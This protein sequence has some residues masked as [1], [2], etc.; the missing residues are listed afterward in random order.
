MRKPQAS[1]LTQLVKNLPAMQ[2][3]RVRFLGWEDPLEKEMAARS[4]ILARTIPW[5][6]EPGGLHSPWG[7]KNRTRQGLNHHYHHQGPPWG[8]SRRHPNQEESAWRAESRGGVP[9][10]D[11]WG[12]RPTE[13]PLPAPEASTMLLLDLGECPALGQSCALTKCALKRLPSFLLRLPQRPRL[14]F[15]TRVHQPLLSLHIHLLCFA[16]D[17]AK[18]RPEE[19]EPL[20]NPGRC[21]CLMP[22]FL[23][24]LCKLMRPA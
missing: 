10:T 2:E 12:Q 17:A 16:G 18:R 15:P 11:G 21:H 4:S 5:T 19:W 14:V 13:P 23:L 6:E 3:T 7:L 24:R 22:A 8:L 9:K 20:P 1:L